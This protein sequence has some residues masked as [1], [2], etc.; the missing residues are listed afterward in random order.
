MTPTPRSMSEQRAR[1]LTDA[2]SVGLEL[3]EKL[4]SGESI[5]TAV[6]IVR[7]QTEAVSD[8]YPA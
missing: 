8:G 6:R 7:I 5:L 2:F 1:R 3:R 4:R